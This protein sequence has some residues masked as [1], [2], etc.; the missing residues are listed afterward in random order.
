MSSAELQ[1]RITRLED[2]EAIKQLK[3]RYCEICD[4]EGYDADAMASLFTEDGRWD[5][6]GVGKAEGRE[7]IRELFAGFPKGIAGAQ[8]IVANPLID[9][10]GDRARGVWYLIAGVSDGTKSEWGTGRYHEEYVKQNGEW[11]FRRVRVKSTAASD[12]PST[13]QR[14]RHVTEEGR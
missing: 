5:G 13:L 3:A 10:D 11:K 8:H 6:E 9:V 12:A 1:E 7:A 2:I 4:H 14:A